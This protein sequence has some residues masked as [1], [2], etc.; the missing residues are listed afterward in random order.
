L[1]LTPPIVD[2]LNE[3][4]ELQITFGTQISDAEFIDISPNGTS[5]PVIF[6]LL[7]QKLIKI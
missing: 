7:L 4:R 1:T 6:E 2:S 3:L 5:D